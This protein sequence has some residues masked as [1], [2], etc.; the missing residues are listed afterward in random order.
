MKRVNSLLLVAKESFS[1]LL[2]PCKKNGNILSGTNNLTLDYLNPFADLNV[3]LPK[4]IYII[5]AYVELV[6]SALATMLFRK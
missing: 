6:G 4:L 3:V 5:N 1:I 2:F